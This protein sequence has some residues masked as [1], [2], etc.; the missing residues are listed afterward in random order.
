MKIRVLRRHIGRRGVAAVCIVLALF[1]VTFLLLLPRWCEDMVYS[2]FY[3]HDDRKIVE[4]TKRAMQENNQRLNHAQT[5]LDAYLETHGAELAKSKPGLILTN[6]DMHT[7]SG[8]SLAIGVLAK[9]RD[10][11]GSARYQPGYLTQTVAALHRAAQS[12]ALFTSKFMYIC[13]IDEDP[14]SF[15]ESSYVIDY[16]VMF[17]KYNDKLK[18]WKQR[19]AELGGELYEKQKSDYVYCL[20]NALNH[21]KADYV[22]ILED[23]VIVHERFFEFLHYHLQT[24]LAHKIEQGFVHANQWA[25][26][27][28]SYP[29]R[30][31]GFSKSL[32]SVS[33]LITFSILGGAIFIILCIGFVILPI[34]SFGILSKRLKFRF[35]A[36]VSTPKPMRGNL[37]TKL[38]YVYLLGAIFTLFLCYSIGRPYLQQ[39]RLVSPYLQRLESSAPGCCTLA[40][41]YPRPIAASLVT[42]LNS[43]TCNIDFAL[44]SAVDEFAQVKSLQTFLV[45][46]NI[47]V[48]IGLVSNLR[49]YAKFVAEYLNINL[50]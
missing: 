6:P 38:L 48:H 28:L 36:F 8:A 21:T 3:V 25:F 37:T 31:R 14:N 46:P 23:D 35:G 26:V 50:V 40:V 10:Q 47:A 16:A 13:N 22:I 5:F 19:S 43:V 2:S 11:T 20:E 4:Y 39:V 44:D 1:G 29:A 30:W 32:S 17:S 9:N 45:E 41:L 18:K 24:N 34:K 27:K 49:G 42:Y 15:Y 7:G 12:D 33:E